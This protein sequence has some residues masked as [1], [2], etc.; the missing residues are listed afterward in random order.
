ML[1]LRVIVAA[2]IVAL[3]VPCA[4]QDLMTTRGEAVELIRDLRRIH[5]PE[6]IELLEQVELNGEKQWINIRGKNK[7][8]PVLLFV[9]G[10]PASP[11]MPISWAY[12]NPWEDFFTVV[13]WDQR[14]SGKNWV[15][16]DTAAAVKQLSFNTFVKDGV[17]LVEYLCDK[18]GKEKIFVMGYSFGASVGVQLATEVPHRLYAYMGVGQTAP[19]DPEKYLYERLLALATEAKHDEA[20]AALQA[21]T[22]YPNADGATPVKKLL[23]ARKWARYFNGGWYGKPDLNLYFSLPALSPEYTEQEIIS[24][25]RSTPWA[26]R[27]ILRKGRETGLPT[28][29]Q[30]PVIFLM[31]RHDL[32]TPYE[33][34][35]LYFDKLTAPMKKFYTFERSGHFPMLEEPGKFLMVL[36]NDV[37]PLAGTSAEYPSK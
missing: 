16:A 1:Y 23:V 15:T 30:V 22:P 14:V 24:L 12:Q 28:A 11:M 18:L 2:L 6:G 31:G 34:T 7:A 29:F 8:N 9:H 35:R 25:D 10:G 17:A 33:P 19:G 26:T 3:S 37:L 20:L 4:A 13:Q 21:L 27:K 36:V 5:T 32:H